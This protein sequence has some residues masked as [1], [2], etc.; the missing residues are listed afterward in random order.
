MIKVG[1]APSDSMKDALRPV[2]RAMVGSELLKNADVDVKF[3][4]VSCL[5][6]LS[7]ITA[8]QQPYDDG[9]MK[10]SKI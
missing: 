6:E 3:S 8:P 5:C 2:M 9:L 4:V 7:R 10:V 1:Q